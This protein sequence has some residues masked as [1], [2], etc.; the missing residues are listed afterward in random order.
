M[1]GDEITIPRG[2]RRYRIRGLAKNLSP[3]VM[4]VN[5]LCRGRT[6]FT[7]IRWICRPTASAP[8]SSSAPPRSWACKEDVIRKD[9]GQ[10]FLTLERLQSE[11][12]RKALEPAKPEVHSAT[13]TAPKRWRC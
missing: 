13:K 4:K 1:I 11:Q 6:S 5:V 3:E 7:S 9:V 10:V 12:I 8:L 2:D